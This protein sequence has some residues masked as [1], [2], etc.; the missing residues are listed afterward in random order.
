MCCCYLDL[1][2]NHLNLEVVGNCIEIAFAFVHF[3]YPLQVIAQD[4]VSVR[5]KSSYNI[6]SRAVQSIQYM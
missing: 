4:L 1:N 5:Y 2:H 3:H 6:A